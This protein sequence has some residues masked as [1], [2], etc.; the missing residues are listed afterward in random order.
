MHCPLPATALSQLPQH[1]WTSLAPVSLHTCNPAS[2]HHTSLLHPSPPHHMPACAHCCSHQ[3]QHSLSLPHLSPQ[4]NYFIQHL[5]RKDTLEPLGYEG[6]ADPQAAKAAA[7]AAAAARSALAAPPPA[8]AG[9]VIVVGAGP[10]G[11]AAAT[12]LKVRQAWVVSQ[13]LRS[14]CQAKARI[15]TDYRHRLTL[16]VG[17][18]SADPLPTSDSLSVTGIEIECS[19]ALMVPAAMARLLLLI[20]IV[21][22]MSGCAGAAARHGCRQH[23]LAC[24]LHTCAYAAVTPTHACLPPFHHTTPHPPPHAPALPYRTAQ[25]R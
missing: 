3:T 16:E 20:L 23:H 8:P 5:D 12:Q 14:C 13:C 15:G 1:I 11:L 21:L 24:I 4:V 6:Q 22:L 9:R 7:A 19:Q 18:S 25:R 17:T 10:A 2:R